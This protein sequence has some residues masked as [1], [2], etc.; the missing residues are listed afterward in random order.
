MS[1]SCLQKC[2]VNDIIVWKNGLRERVISHSKSGVWPIAI[3]I[4]YFGND[5]GSNPP[6]LIMERHLPIIIKIVKNKA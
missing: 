2:R 4:D 6:G 1:L 3:E 5:V